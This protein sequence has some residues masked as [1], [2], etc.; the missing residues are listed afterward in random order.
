MQESLFPERY[1]SVSGVHSCRCAR[2]RAFLGE[3]YRQG[4]RSSGIFSFQGNHGLC[5]ETGSG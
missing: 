3:K 5:Y 2:G 4:T 1:K